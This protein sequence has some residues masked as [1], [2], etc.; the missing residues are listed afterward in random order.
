VR[1]A[2]GLLDRRDLVVDLRVVAREERAAVDDH[3][4][5]VGPGRDR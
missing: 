5:L 4:D 3:V 1:G 2:A